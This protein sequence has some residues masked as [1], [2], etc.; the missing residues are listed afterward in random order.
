MGA[1]RDLLTDPKVRIL[2]FGW[3]SA[4]ENK[5]QSTFQMGQSRCVW[6]VSLAYC[7]SGPCLY[8]TYACVNPG[9]VQQACHRQS[10]TM[11]CG[12]HLIGF[13]EL[14]GPASCGEAAE[15]PGQHGA[16]EAHQA[17]GWRLRRL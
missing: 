5:M 1:R 11:L 12:C 2:G 3:E 4:D 14:P 8:P 9:G 7:F 16:A 17:G 10:P 6:A 15:L 13:R